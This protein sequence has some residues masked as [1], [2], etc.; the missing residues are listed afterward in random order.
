MTV[1]GTP[2]AVRELEGRRNR[3]GLPGR[4][5]YSRL[6]GWGGRVVRSDTG[7]SVGFEF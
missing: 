5:H 3:G 6:K 1:T 7:C 4:K 2:G